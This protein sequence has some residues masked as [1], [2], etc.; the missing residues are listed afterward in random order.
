MVG[1][2]T[3]NIPPRQAEARETLADITQAHTILDWSPQ[4][5]LDERINTY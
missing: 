3:T 1:G 2:E 4:Y 5:S